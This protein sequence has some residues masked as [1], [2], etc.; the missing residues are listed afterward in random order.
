M[1]APEKENVPFAYE[2]TNYAQVNPMNTGGNVEVWLLQTQ[3]IMQ[4]TVAQ[5]I[6][7]AMVDYQTKE[8]LDFA[9]CWPGQCVLCVNQIEWAKH[10]EKLKGA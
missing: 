3:Q 6:D 7:D 5:K 2:Q 1:I 10:I 9:I 4:R 8:R